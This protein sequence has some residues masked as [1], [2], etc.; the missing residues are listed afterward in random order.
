MILALFG[1]EETE[2]PRPLWAEGLEERIVDQVAERLT[3]KASVPDQ[4]VERIAARL[5]STPIA[6]V[7]GLRRRSCSTT[8][9]TR[10]TT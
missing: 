4:V 1:H 5:V 2:T 8:E 6:A 9:S 3:G 10:A 7:R